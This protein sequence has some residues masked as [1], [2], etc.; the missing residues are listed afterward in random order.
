MPTNEEIRIKDIIETATEADL[1]SGNYFGLDCAD[2]T[3]KL[4]GNAIAPRSV[5]DNAVQSLAPTF[6]PT[7]TENNPYKVHELVMYN[8]ILKECVEPH[9]G[10]WDSNH[11]VTSSV[12][13]NFANVKLAEENIGDFSLGKNN[14]VDIDGVQHNIDLFNAS[15]PVPKDERNWLQPKLGKIIDAYIY[16]NAIVYSPVNTKTIV[17]K[18]PKNKSFLLGQGAYNRLGVLVT[19]SYPVDGKTGQEFKDV[20]TKDGRNYI[21]F[22]TNRGEYVSVFFYNSLFDAPATEN[23]RLST[24]SCSSLELGYVDYVS[25]G[26]FG[27]LLNTSYINPDKIADVFG[28]TSNQINDI[29]DDIYS[30]TAGTSISP[31]DQYPGKSISQLGNYNEAENFTAIRFPASPFMFISG[32]SA[33]ASGQCLAVVFDTFGNILETIEN[34]TGKNY[35]DL[36]VKLPANASNIVV[37]CVSNFNGAK[38]AVLSYNGSEVSS[39]ISAI[40]QAIFVNSPGDEIVE[41]E[42]YAE[43][44]LLI[45]GNLQDNSGFSVREYDVEGIDKIYVSGR[46]PGNASYCLAVAKNSGGDVVSKY[47]VGTGADYN[48][49]LLTLPDS[50]VTLLVNASNSGSHTVKACVKEKAFYT[51]DEALALFGGNQ[52]YWRGKKIWW[53]G[54]SIPAGGYPQIVGTNLG[55]EVTNKAVGGSMCR[56]NVRTG[57]YV[58]ANFENITSCL[59]M[60]KAEIENF[61]INYSTIQPTLT[62]NAPATLSASYITRLRSASFE[63]R[64]I[65][66]LDGTYDFPNLFVIDHGHNDFKYTLPD[67]SSDIGLEPTLANI[68]SGIL[69]ED[70]YMTANNNEKLVSFLGSIDNIK[71]ADKP[72]F[73]A[74]LNRNCYKGSI[75]FLVTLI[76]KYN[77]FARIVFISNYEHENGDYPRYAP[78][79]TAQQDN[80]NSWAF[81]LCEV[82]RKLGYSNHIIPGTKNIY[83]G[84]YSFDY[85]IDAFKVYCPD[86]VHPH[87]QPDGISNAIYAGILAEFLKTCR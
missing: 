38:N 9:Y 25:P 87:S 60:T 73:I 39:D 53:C 67:D 16:N 82:Y 43:K 11:F 64:L 36:L 71:P 19:D 81:P 40:N 17:F 72:A 61:I 23:D 33:G 68:S 83:S 58:G 44:A 26:E 6:D 55:A 78:L 35:S 15:T 22:H 51:K 75:N 37:N 74:S 77:P 34:A 30:K 85:D 12:N 65:P 45:S 31:L 13:E 80:A 86:K 50:A 54:T 24:L 29:K 70:T 10:A 5:M 41:D 84:A 63:D 46:S 18:M 49:Y 57:D 20:V 48:D 1:I 69:A 62:G 32:R 21:K 14:V 28:N 3:K 2:V 59:T 47:E 79:I 52:S 42:T 66:Y 56:A 7:R 76:L 4:H 27:I 8:G